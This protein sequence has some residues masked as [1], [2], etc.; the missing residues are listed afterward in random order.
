MQQ[1]ERVKSQ[2]LR[3]YRSEEALYAQGL[4]DGLNQGRKVLETL[5]E[6]LENGERREE[7][8]SPTEG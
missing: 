1:K 7:S 2:A 3:A 4:V 8:E 6:E 5:M